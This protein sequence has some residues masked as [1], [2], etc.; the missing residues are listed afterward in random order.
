LKI[1]ITETLLP[2]IMVGSDPRPQWFT[3]QLLEGA[4]GGRSDRAEGIDRRLTFSY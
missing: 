2:T 3:P 4:R 1:P